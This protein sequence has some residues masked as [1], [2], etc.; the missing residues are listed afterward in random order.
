ML[1]YQGQDVYEPSPENFQNSYIVNGRTQQSAVG[2]RPDGT[3]LF[4]LPNLTAHDSC[5][6]LSFRD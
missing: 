2:V 1:L 4:V 3:V 6:C 5:H